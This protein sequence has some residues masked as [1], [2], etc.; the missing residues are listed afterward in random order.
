[1]TRWSIL[2]LAA[3]PLLLSILQASASASLDVVDD[4]RASKGSTLRPRT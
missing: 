2:S 1:M 4:H 3:I